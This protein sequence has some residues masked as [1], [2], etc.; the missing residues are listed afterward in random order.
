MKA[1]PID[2]DII[3]P[4]TPIQKPDDSYKVTELRN[5]ISSV[6]Q[7]KKAAISVTVLLMCLF[8]C[9]IIY[10]VYKKCKQP[11]ESLPV[12]NLSFSRQNTGNNFNSNIEIEDK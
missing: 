1:K 6:N 9:L 8:I 11:A 2:V 4:E 12:N 10:V 7:L 5:Q 3:I